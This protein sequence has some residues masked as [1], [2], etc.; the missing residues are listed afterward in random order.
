MAT[1]IE[2]HNDVQVLLQK[3]SGFPSEAIIKIDYILRKAR[4]PGYAMRLRADTDLQNRGWNSIEALRNLRTQLQEQDNAIKA[5]IGQAQTVPPK[6]QERAHVKIPTV[7]LDIGPNPIEEYTLL[8][9]EIASARASLGRIEEDIGKKRID[10]A[11][12]R[13]RILALRSNL[14]QL[15]EMIKEN[16][17]FDP[18]GYGKRF[19]NIGGLREAIRIGEIKPTGQSLLQNAQKTIQIMDNAIQNMDLS[20]GFRWIAGKK[21]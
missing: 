15:V 3:V 7:T 20:A 13:E 1:Y 11:E 2:V 4:D 14:E 6:P 18:E 10:P 21:Q 17:R 12:A 19:D 8:R 16:R 9:R 5:A